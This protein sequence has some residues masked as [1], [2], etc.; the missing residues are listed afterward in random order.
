MFIYKINIQSGNYLWHN[1]YVSDLIDRRIDFDQW[2]FCIVW[3]TCISFLDVLSAVP[4]FL[5]HA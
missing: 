5:S 4:P 2:E 3:A 1:Y